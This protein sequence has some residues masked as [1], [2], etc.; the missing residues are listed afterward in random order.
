MRS[1]TIEHQRPGSRSSSSRLAVSAKITGIKTPETGMVQS[2]SA[3]GVFL[4]SQTDIP[5]GAEC[6]VDLTITGL[7]S[8]TTVFLDGYVT[9]HTEDGFGIHFRS[10]PE[11][12]RLYALIE[13]L[14]VN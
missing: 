13:D 8:V 1:F 14:S 3:Q 6:V 11:W 10:S 5:L 7:I 12:D 4:A 9:K 2:I